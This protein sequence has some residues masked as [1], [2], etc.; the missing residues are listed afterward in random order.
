MPGGDLFSRISDDG[1]M[2]EEEARVPMKEVIDA[3]AYLHRLSIA[4][5]DLKVRENRRRSRESVGELREG[6]REGTRRRRTRVLFT[7]DLARKPCICKQTSKR[8][9]KNY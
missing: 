2:T 8:K 4:H 5:R 3:I 9:I 7:W 1:P 6:R